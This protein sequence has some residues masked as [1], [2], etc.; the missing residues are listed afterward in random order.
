[1]IAEFKNRYPGENSQFTSVRK[2]Q[3]YSEF[4]SFKGHHGAGHANIRIVSLS[5]YMVEAFREN[6]RIRET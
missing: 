6:D 3:I 2:P 1:M 5:K 4:W